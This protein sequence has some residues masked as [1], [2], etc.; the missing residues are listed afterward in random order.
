MLILCGSYVSVMKRECKDSGRPLFGRFSSMMLL[1]PLSFDETRRFHPDMPEE[2]ALRLYLTV[3]GVPRY[4]AELDSDSYDG[5]VLDGYILNDWM[6]E[7][8]EHLLESELP[9]PK[10][11][12]SILSAIGNGST[13]LKDTVMLNLKNI[14]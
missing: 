13:N 5:C 12:I 3:G 7:E 9:N 2:D 10:R 6:M 4:H 8:A 14:I 1:G 11:A